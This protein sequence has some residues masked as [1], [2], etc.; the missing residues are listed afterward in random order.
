MSPLAEHIS[1]MP[2]ADLRANFSD[3]LLQA[4]GET[5]E[6]DQGFPRF[7]TDPQAGQHPAESSPEGNHNNEIG[8]VILAQRYA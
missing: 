1:T 7:D 3:L 2:I 6:D 5:D 4:M 8:G